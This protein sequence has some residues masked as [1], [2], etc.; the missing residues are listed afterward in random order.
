M[1]DTERETGRSGRKR[2]RLQKIRQIRRTLAK[3]MESGGDFSP[4]NWYSHREAIK[5]TEKGE[6]CWIHCS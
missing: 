5:V 6:V 4:V 2:C 1:A 3:L